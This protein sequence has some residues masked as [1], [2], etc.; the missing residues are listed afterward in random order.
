MDPADVKTLAQG[1]ADQ[2][3][4]SRVVD[5]FDQCADQNR[6]ESGL[7]AGVK[8]GPLEIK[9]FAAAQGDV[10]AV[11]N[12]V[13]LK[14]DAVCA[15][16]FQNTGVSFIRGEPKAVGIYLDEGE[17]HAGSHADDF[18]QILSFRRLAA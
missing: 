16:V 7:R 9:A 11:I 15:G 13:E 6:A 2:I 14:V 12:A 10:G 3:A 5:A 4:C 18:R 8:G 17:A 1:E